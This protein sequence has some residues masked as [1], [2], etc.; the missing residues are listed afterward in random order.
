MKTNKLILSGILLSVMLISLASAF[1]FDNIKSVDKHKATITN[2][3]GLGKEIATIELTNYTGYC[4]VGDCWMY[5]TLIIK[6]DG[7][8]SLQDSKLYN[9]NG[10]LKSQGS[11]YQIWDAEQSEESLASNWIC[12]LNRE[13]INLQLPE[14]KEEVTISKQGKW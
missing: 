1:Q 14:C 11:E 3:F 2:G 9:M 10:Q 5:N 12:P 7:L 4:F 13:V 8:E 6:A